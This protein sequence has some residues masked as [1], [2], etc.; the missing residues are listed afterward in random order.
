MND[1]YMDILELDIANEQIE[2]CDNL[3]AFPNY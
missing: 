1:L 2:Y 3:A